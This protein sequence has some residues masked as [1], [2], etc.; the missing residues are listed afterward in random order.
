MRVAVIGLGR[1]GRFYARTIASL[2]PDAQ[3]AAVADPDPVARAAVE[4]ELSV[5]FA[6]SEPADVVGRT[7]VDAVIIATP[8]S[9]HAELVVAAARAGK[10][11]FCE[12]PLALSL[13]HTQAALSAVHA[14]G[15]LLQ[16]GFM[17]RFDA[18]YQNA[19]ALIQAG[20]VGRPLTFKAVGRDPSCPPLGYANPDHSGGLVLD[21][22]IHDFDL[23][24]WLMS[25]EV[26]RVSAD[27]ALLVCTHFSEV[28]DIDNAVINLRFENGAL[29]NV[30][31][32]R[33]AGYGYDVWTEV[34]GSEGSVVV[35]RDVRAA[36][37]ST[38]VQLFTQSAGQENETP[39]F[40]RR[41]GAAYRT[42]I[43]RF[44]ECVEHGREPPV[45]GA[46]ALA[47]FEI[48][49]AATRSWQTGHPVAVNEVREPTPA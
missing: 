7:D 16:M 20:R 26:E 9:S 27:G 35:G 3:L 12:K 38:G 11:I 5:P 13:Q 15:V 21:M 25:S 44:V 31:I 1:M 23:A 29:G 42:Q 10:A 14:A 4:R 40:V 43:E 22:G 24:R 46:D 48:G 2:G 33:N 37:D 41:F 30:E 47:A 8:T 45:G 18:G 6:A 36:A 34:L 17:R 49:L 39:H 19:R 28:G 32:S